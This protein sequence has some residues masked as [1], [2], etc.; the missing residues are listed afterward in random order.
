[1]NKLYR[2]K[3][4]LISIAIPEKFGYAGPPLQFGYDWA[5]YLDALSKYA[6]KFPHVRIALYINNDVKSYRKKKKY[7]T[8]EL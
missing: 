1:M 6:K 4:D 8:M 5:R 2:N 7:F 3:K